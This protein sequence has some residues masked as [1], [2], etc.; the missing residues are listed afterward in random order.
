MSNGVL[1]LLAG[2]GSVRGRG[3][4]TC[5]CPPTTHLT[6]QAAVEKKKSLEIR[7]KRG[8][9]Y[10][11]VLPSQNG[12]TPADDGLASGPPT[13]NERAHPAI[14]LNGYV[15]RRRC[16]EEPCVLW[17]SELP[18]FGL[19][20][21]PTGY[22]CWIVAFRERGIKRLVTLGSVATLDARKAR[23]EA[24][25]R[26]VAN[27]LDGLPQ[28]PKPKAQKGPS[29]FRDYVGAFWADYARHW[30][31]STQKRNLSLV[32]KEL[33]PAFGDVAVEAF[34]RAE[35]VR[36]RD[37]L[38]QRPCTFNRA[39]PVLAVML[40]YAEQLGHRRCGSNPCKGMPRFKTKVHE[41]YLT[42]AEYRRLASTLDEAEVEVPLAVAA[43][44]L[45]IYTGA[46]SGE[47]TTLRWEYVQPP[48]LALPDSKTGPKTIYLNGPAMAVLDDL[49]GRRSG[50]VFAS[51]AQPDRPIR[52]DNHWTKLRRSATLPDVRLHDLRHSFASVAIMDG[53]SLS[54]IGKLLGHALPETMARYAHL[55][56]E[57]VMDAA[58]RVCSSLASALG[59]PA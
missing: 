11:S 39:L 4:A 9:R 33:L 25:K 58:E 2:S 14:R 7:H 42:A 41:R 54:L 20:M 50:L 28:P 40:A 22:K 6:P 31:P 51:P 3:P 47:I 5:F 24:R 53:I 57:A 34:T 37:G 23:N 17:D 32:R 21:R 36:W 48:R 8:R 56:D 44:R 52:I 27:R 13:L 29:L 45:L 26:L 16:P 38:N 55:A 49:P 12:P 19:R 18:G 15:A 1:A 59:L 35:I 43:I 30:K 10:A 46:R